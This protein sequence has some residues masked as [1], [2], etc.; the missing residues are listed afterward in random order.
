MYEVLH[1]F[2]TEKKSMVKTH[3]N[4]LHR[5]II[6]SQFRL[7]ERILRSLRSALRGTVLLEVDSLL[8]GDAHAFAG[9]AVV[10]HEPTIIV[11]GTAEYVR[12]FQRKQ[13][14]LL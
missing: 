2:R 8:R 12:E 11:K 10:L 13:K 3:H 5:A 6:F 7:P 4:Y 9:N 1:T 14:T